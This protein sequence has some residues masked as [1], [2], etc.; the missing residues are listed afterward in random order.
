MKVKSDH[1]RKEYLRLRM[2]HCVYSKSHLKNTHLLRLLH[3]EKTK[4]QNKKFSRV[5]GKF[6][7]K[8]TEKED[9]KDRGDI[10]QVSIKDEVEGMIMKENAGRFR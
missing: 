9:H 4:R 10:M 7:M 5:F 3:K 6:R 2:H 8:A 1:N